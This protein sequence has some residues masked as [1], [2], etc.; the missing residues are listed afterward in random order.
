MS[1]ESDL[2]VISELPMV[3]IWGEAFDEIDELKAYRGKFVVTDDGK[4]FAKL[5][6]MEEW[7]QVQLFHDM[8]VNDLGV[9]DPK[10]MDIKDVVTGGGKIDIEAKNG[11]LECRLYGKSVIYGDYEPDLIDEEALRIEIREVFD[12]DEVPVHIDSDAED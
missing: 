3:K 9:E 6:P 8:V 12:Y 10:S 5:F 7:D 4:F 11:R 1:V 2:E